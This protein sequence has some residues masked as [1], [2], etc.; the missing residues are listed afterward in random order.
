MSKRDARTWRDRVIRKQASSK[1][2][3]SLEGS[4]LGTQCLP[5]N[6]TGRPE[7]MA[8]SELPRDGDVRP[9]RLG[10]A[11]SS[12][13]GGKAGVYLPLPGET[14]LA[15]CTLRG[16]TRTPSLKQQHLP[17]RGICVS[18]VMGGS[19]LPALESPHLP[20]GLLLEH[21]VPTRPETRYRP[22]AFHLDEPKSFVLFPSV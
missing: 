1:A 14:R 8:D 10:T 11:M 15:R 3:G 22:W 9:Q 5:R 21:L 6:S 7:A 13:G 2:S 18:V 12:T 20:H 17:T 19:P 16:Q 4:P